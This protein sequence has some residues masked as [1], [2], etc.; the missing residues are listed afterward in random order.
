MSSSRL[1]RLV[2][3]GPDFALGPIGSGGALELAGTLKLDGRSR[4]TGLD[5]VE[6]SLAW[7]EAESGAVIELP[8]DVELAGSGVPAGARSPR[9]PQA[10]PGC[11]CA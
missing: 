2:H 9:C 8:L 3:R 10:T 4:K 11:G 7:I 6:L 5:A 1:A